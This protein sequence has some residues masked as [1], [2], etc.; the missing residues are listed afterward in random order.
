MLALG[1][2]PWK[3]EYYSVRNPPGAEQRLIGGRLGDDNDDYRPRGRWDAW[4]PGGHRIA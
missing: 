1:K 2:P 4:A 3:F